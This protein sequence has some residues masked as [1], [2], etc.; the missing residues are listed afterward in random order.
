[1]ILF[2][3]ILGLPMAALVTAG[4]FF[5]MAGMIKEK[6]EGYPSP[7]PVPNFNITAEIVES[8]PISPKPPTT[9]PKELP[10]TEYDFQRVDG[11]GEIN[12]PRPGPVIVDKRPPGPGTAIGPVIRIPPAYPE[13]CRTRGAAGSVIVEFDV[14]PEGN[15]TNAR[16]IE[17]P[18][19]CFER[20]VLKAVSGWKYPPAPSGG[21][22]YGVIEGF[23]FQLTE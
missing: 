9:I 3:W 21:M 12:A 13:R 16:I 19:R 20:P 7:K 11:P 1:M 10:P 6:N 4:L 5:M 8:D 18:D 2:R 22:R 14:T 15:V 17:S 23:S